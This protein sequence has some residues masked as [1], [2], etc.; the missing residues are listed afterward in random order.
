MSNVSLPRNFKP[1]SNEFVIFKN[2]LQRETCILAQSQHTV[3]ENAS[4]IILYLHLFHS[5]CCV[6]SILFVLDQTLPWT[7]TSLIFWAFL[8][9][10]PL[11]GRQ[12]KKIVWLCK[13][14]TFN[15]FLQTME[16]F[17]TKVLHPQHLPNPTHHRATTSGCG[18]YLPSGSSQRPLSW[19]SWCH[20]CASSIQSPAPRKQAMVLHSKSCCPLDGG[21]NYIKIQQPK[22]KYQMISL[23]RGI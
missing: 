10:Q 5:I 14:S 23:L 4:E 19:S 18:C 1:C 9:A 7:S 11:R 21:L 20:T 13:R 16:S 22:G 12:E 17:L 15:N 8:F 6:L 3:R 2:I